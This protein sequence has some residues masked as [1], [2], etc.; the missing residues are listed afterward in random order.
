MERG[1]LLVIR[2]GQYHRPAML[3]QSN[4]ERIT[5]NFQEAL[6]QHFSTAKSDLSSIFREHS[7]Q[8]VFFVHLS[9][10]QLHQYLSPISAMES[11][12]DNDSFG[13]DVL[14]QSLLTQLFVLTNRAFRTSGQQT[15]NIM[16]KA[17]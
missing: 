11:L 7:N 9:E 6:L 10:E 16:P 5:L 3:D 13:T 2:P 17:L 1:D 14:I 4:Y 12:L 8:T 15:S